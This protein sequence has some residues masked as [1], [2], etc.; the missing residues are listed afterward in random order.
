MHNQVNSR[1]SSSKPILGG[2]VAGS[3]YMIKSHLGQDDN[4][5]HNVMKHSPSGKINI[6]RN[7]PVMHNSNAGISAKIERE[8]ANHNQS[9][10]KNKRKETL[11][12]SIN[13]TKLP[14]LTQQ[15][16]ISKLP[17][18]K[19]AMSPLDS[20]GIKITDAMGIMNG[21]GISRERSIVATVAA[22]QPHNGMKSSAVGERSLERNPS[23]LSRKELM[24]HEC[25]L[26]LET[27]L[28]NIMQLMSSEK[29]LGLNYIENK[30]NVNV[31]NGGGSKG[32]KKQQPSNFNS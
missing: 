6:H 11:N 23:M 9:G 25:N 14:N 21:L 17:T 28:P 30:T 18:I 31:E 3:K 27:R 8:S 13:Q 15:S 2:G 12:Q 1:L 22:V 7:Q 10:T 20:D 29:S 16:A 4:S 5:V 26:L 32:S 19:G 24:K